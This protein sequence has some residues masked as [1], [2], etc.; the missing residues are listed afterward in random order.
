MLGQIKA[1]HMGYRGS[2][3]EHTYSDQ[4]GLIGFDVSNV[5][6]GVRINFILPNSAATKT[7]VSLQ[8]GDVITAVNGKEIGKNTNFYSLL[9][10]TSGNEILL[11]LENAKEVVVRTESTRTIRELCYK[12]W[13][14][15]SYNLV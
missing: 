14:N 7:N 10:N 6:K 8:I 1:S 12:E 13:L 5:E 11:T 15:Y 3:P 9:K 4:V 2:T